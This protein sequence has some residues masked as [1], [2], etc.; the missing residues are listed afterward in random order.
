M[1]PIGRFKLDYWLDP[2]FE[3]EVRRETGLPPYWFGPGAD[4]VGLVG[5]VKLH[6]LQQFVEH[7][8]T[9]NHTQRRMIQSP[10][11]GFE[12]IPSLHKSLP[13][14][15][16]NA[17]DPTT[18]ELR[19]EL[20]R[21]VREEFA[22]LKL[23]ARGGAG[24][25]VTLE[26]QPIIAIAPQGVSKAGDPQD[27]WHVYVAPVAWVPSEQKLLSFDQPRFYRDVQLVQDRINGRAAELFRERL[28][29][30]TEIKHRI[31]YCP[32]VPQGCVVAASRRAQQIDEYLR[33]RRVPITPL[34]RKIAAHATRDWNGQRPGNPKLHED[35]RRLCRQHGFDPTK[36]YNREKS[37]SAGVVEA[38]RLVRRAADKVAKRQ[39]VFTRLE[40][41]AVVHRLG[42]KARIPASQLDQALDRVY[43]DWARFGVHR[44]PSGDYTTSLGKAAWQHLKAKAEPLAR[45]LSKLG[46]VAQQGAGHVAAAGKKAAAG[47]KKAAGAG[48]RA[49]AKARSAFKAFT[50][51]AGSDE[52]WVYDATRFLKKVTPPRSRTAAHLKA[53][54]SVLG[55]GL[56]GGINER[57]V[58]AERVY[59]LNRT[60]RQSLRCGDHLVIIDPESQR[61]DDVMRLKNLAEKRGATWEVK[62]TL[63]AAAVV[64]GPDQP[65]GQSWQMFYGQAQQPSP[66]ATQT[67]NSNH[68][69]GRPR[70]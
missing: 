51:D 70:P 26:G 15:R 52:F 4:A 54:L 8:L 11:P 55:W 12:V 30:R 2:S 34:S 1:T 20:D 32:D 40:H 6:E 58:H 45:D 21:I 24:G 47:G 14:A 41:E 10:H 17:G 48:M 67:N 31:L 49:A 28:G 44:L 9:P 39:G 27:H 13:L 46:T 36:V 19:Q 37:R 59:A 66:G 60:P 23:F 38:V 29:T 35:T 68:N 53:A 69:Q 63:R 5:A 16:I 64:N 62:Y 56:V 25:K 50:S 65:A 3:E 57:L 43:G 22:Y 42:V 33:E 7:G 18:K 61:P